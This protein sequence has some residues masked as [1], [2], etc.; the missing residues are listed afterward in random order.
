MP[1]SSR[2]LSTRWYIFQ[3]YSFAYT[4][5]IHQEIADGKRIKQPLVDRIILQRIRIIYAIEVRAPL[6]LYHNTKLHQYRISMIM[7]GTQFQRLVQII[8]I[9]IVHR[10]ICGQY[11]QTKSCLH[12]RLW[13][14]ATYILRIAYLSYIKR[15]DATNIQRIFE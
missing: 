5:I 11:L 8:D 4:S 12:H 6:A 10:P 3:H 14:S 7:E 9:R 2:I 13:K 1:R 15:L